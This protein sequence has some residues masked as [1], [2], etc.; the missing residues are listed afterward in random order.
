MLNIAQNR[1]LLNLSNALAKLSNQVQFLARL[2]MLDGD[3]ELASTS[4]HDEMTPKR[5]FPRGIQLL[6]YLFDRT[7]HINT[8][9]LYFVL[10]SILRLSAEPYFR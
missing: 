5:E 4:S 1:R 8:R 2:C 6:S 10:V 9:E 7:M 3:K